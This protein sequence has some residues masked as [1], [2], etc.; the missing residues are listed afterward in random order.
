[1]STQSWELPTDPLRVA[2]VQAE[3]V[4]GDLAGNAATAARTVTAAGAGAAVAVLPELFLPAYHPDTL[5]ADPAGTDLAADHAGRV[6]DPRL[7]PL[8][9]AAR[10]ARVVVVVGAAVRHPDGRRACSALLVDRTGQVTCG[11]DKQHLCGPDER[12]LF[13]P[14]RRGA[15]L[16]VDGWRLGLGVCYDGCFPE[17]G[18]AAADDGAHGYLCPAAYRDGSQHRRDLYYPARALENTMYV[19][20]ANPVGGPPPW[21]FNGGAAVYDPEGRPLRRAPDHGTAIV[22][23]SCEPAVL[24][25][26]RAAHPMLADR[27]PDQGTDR[28]TVGDLT[29]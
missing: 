4:P 12:E 24:A 29:G 6:D 1:M 25:E 8:R 14:G 2:A 10:D 23:A 9:L 11:Y 18:R 7:D 5:R 19:V 28:A 15:T 16:L 26:V 20:F 21:R 13:V 17:H 22:V 3:A 27:L